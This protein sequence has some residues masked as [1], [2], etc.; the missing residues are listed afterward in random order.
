MFR[1]ATASLR[2]ASLAQRASPLKLG[3]NAY[4]PPPPPS[5]SREKN[6]IG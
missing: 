4:G 6:G 3:T 5:R 1:Q 2:P